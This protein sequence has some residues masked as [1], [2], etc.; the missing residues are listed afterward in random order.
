M[1]PKTPRT[2]PATVQKT[3]TPAAVRRGKDVVSARSNLLPVFPV[4]GIGASAG[5]LEAFTQLLSCLPSDTGMAF[6]LIQ[7]LDPQHDS[8]LAHALSRATSMPVVQITDGMWIEPNNVYVIPPNADAAIL[9]GVLTLLP[10]PTD[11]RRPHLPVDFF[12]RALAADLGKQAIGVVLSGTASDGTAGLKAIKAADGIALV[13]DPTTAKF[14]GMPQSAIDAAVADAI[15]TPVELAEELGRLARHPYVAEGATTSP[16]RLVTKQDDETLKKIFVVVRNAVGVDYTEYKPAT[17]ERRLARRMAVRKTATRDAYLK[18]LLEDPDEPKLLYEDVLIHVTSFFRDPEAFEQIK[19]N[20]FPAILGNKED[21]APIRLWIAG[22][23]TGE[24]VY[25]LTI[26]LTEYL[27]GAARSHPIQIF[28]TDISEKAIEVARAGVYSD[29]ALRDV[30][31]ERRRRFFTKV[32]RGYRISKS[33]RELCVFVRHDLARDPPFS[34]LDLVS[35]RN[36][37][38]YFGAELQKRIIATFHYCLNSPGFL[39]LGRTESISGFNQFFTKTDRGGKSFARTARRSSL[40]FS[41]RAGSLNAETHRLAPVS[42]DPP[43]PTTD[44]AKYVD[45]LLLS[46]YAPAGVLVNEKL[47]VLQFRGRTGAYLEPPTGTPQHNL[48]KMAREGLLS[49][50]RMAFGEA[51]KANDVR[52]RRGAVVGEDG[53]SRTCDVVVAPIRAPDSEEQLFLVLFESCV[54]AAPEERRRAGKK[55]AGKIKVPRARA[56]ADLASELASTKEYLE[57]LVEDHART[58]DDLASANEEFVSNNEEL[59]SLNE[60]L[61]TAKEEL[62]S[63]NEELTTVND[64]LHSRNQEVSQSNGDLVNLLNTVDIPVVMLDAERRVKRFTPRA[65]AVLNVQAT[66]VG[67]PIDEIKPNID[68]TDLEQRVAAVIA[69]GTPAEWEVRDRQDRWYRLQIMP[70]QNSEGVIDGAI[71]SLIDIDALKH[72]VSDAEW[73]RDYAVAIVEAVQIPLVVLDEELRVRSAN[74]AFYDTFRTTADATET[75]RLFDLDGGQWNIEELR[76][77]LERMLSTKEKIVDLEVDYDFPRVGRRVM[78]VSASAVQSRTDLP[79]ILLTIEDITTRKRADDERAELL[80]RT[81]AAKQDA[82]RANLAK[83]EFLAMLSHELRTPLST[84][85]MQSQLLRR[86]AVDIVKIHRISDTIERATRLQVQLIDDL[87]DVSRIVTGKLQIELEEVDLASVIQSALENVS[88]LALAKGVR[89]TVEIEPAMAKLS[90]DPVRLLQVVS[91]LLTNAVK[92]SQKDG[93]VLVSLTTIDGRAALR[94]SDEGRGIEPGFLPHI[95]DRFTQQDSSTTRLFGGLGL[96]LAIVRHIVD[97]HG[98][99][100]R[101]ESPGP[102][103]GATFSVTLPLSPSHEDSATPSA[104]HESR[105]RPRAGHD[106]DEQLR[107]LRVLLVDDDSTIRETTT[108]ILNLLG[109]SVVATPSAADGLRALDAARFDVILCDI[110]MPG[111]DGYDFIRLLR[112]LDPQHGGATPAIAFTAFAGDHNRARSLEAGFQLHL[113]K[114]VDLERLAESVKLLVERRPPPPN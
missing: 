59:Q 105:P 32:D 17:L 18:V 53:E 65:R 21:G 95:F 92:F 40:T 1:T 85:L 108:E 106:G 101:A 35:C 112:E 49:P 107:G 102:G 23:S 61:E 58:N 24:E 63:T 3:S 60:E 38:I 54:E 55:P 25:S 90:G 93:R 109:A 69:T 83:D 43:R 36:V 91:N 57:S 84:L 8:L 26:A 10:R 97:R 104:A 9:H 6:V 30:S 114:P 41:P 89:F 56:I 14:V 96:G 74:H 45:R 33:V 76:Q 62:Q 113:S 82:E 42:G 66:D 99:S 4:V 5:G 79:M 52:R 2:A 44:L 50:L 75:Q 68:V 28:G 67:R 71:V 12:L 11:T 72:N 80:R 13:Q 7:H 39:L 103:K 81:Q 100:V 78:H 20:V 48:L 87:L 73:A 94:I 16:P 86:G 37:L 31:D 27:D 110:A 15:L 47:D 34:K 88:A 111:Q 70:S 64:E 98:G 19:R 77:P 46:K 29:G 51:K 22:C